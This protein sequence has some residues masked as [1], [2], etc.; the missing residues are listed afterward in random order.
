V[1]CFLLAM[2]NFVW[3]S[4]G[5]TTI[6]VAVAWLLRRAVQ[7]GR[8]CP[9]PD[10]LARAYAL[11]AILPPVFAAWIVAATLGPEIVLEPATFRDAHPGSGSHEHLLGELIAPL[12][13]AARVVALALFAGTM[14][15]VSWRRLRDYRLVA[16][17]V[18]R[19]RARPGRSDGPQAELVRAVAARRGLGVSLLNVDGPVC[20][21]WGLWRPRLVLSTA[22][23]GALTPD[24]ARGVAEH[25]VA[26]CAR[27]D[28][29]VKA[30]VDACVHASLAMPIAR[31]LRGW[32][33]EQAELAC[34]EIAARRTGAPL[35]IADALVKLSR[36]ACPVRLA[37]D[38]P[39]FVSR[40][41]ALVEQRVRRLMSLAGTLSAPGVPVSGDPW[42]A[43]AALAGLFSASLTGLLLLAPLAVHRAAELALQVLR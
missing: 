7:T 40:D 31:R 6:G 11:A 23:L 38:A 9:R 24:E 19:L 39:A 29:A 18:T 30:V 3:L 8:W 17:V 35:D 21:V 5:L 4:T 14:C 34:D 1:T 41:R 13:P 15:A 25:E 33:T 27:R 42:R 32:Y 20:F 22:I 37:V 16:T 12:E 2:E 36:Q 26:H 43:A 10:R 28:S